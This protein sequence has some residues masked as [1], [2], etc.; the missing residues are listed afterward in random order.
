VNALSA[1]LADKLPSAFTVENVL[2]V[3]ADLDF[4]EVVACCWGR[5]AAGTAAAVEA[6]AER[7]LDAFMEAATRE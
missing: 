4:T 2:M 5:D 7:Y 3:Q 6:F 1:Y